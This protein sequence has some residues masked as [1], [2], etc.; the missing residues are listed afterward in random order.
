MKGKDNAHVVGFREN[1]LKREKLSRLT[2]RAGS[3]K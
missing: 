3:A 1:K 2:W